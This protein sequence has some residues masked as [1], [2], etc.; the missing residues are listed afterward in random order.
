MKRGRKENKKERER[1]RARA[2]E[3][4]VLRLGVSVL[5]LRMALGLRTVRIRSDFYKFNFNSLVMVF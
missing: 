3:R 2:T 4:R 5:G 1:E